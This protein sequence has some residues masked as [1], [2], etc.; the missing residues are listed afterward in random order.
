MTIRKVLPVAD[1]YSCSLLLAQAKSFPGPLSKRA[2]A[3]I[4]AL[5]GKVSVVI[6][7][8]DVF[9]VLRVTL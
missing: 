2:L 6:I 1:S 8:H 3:V 4:E 9:V 5:E 7:R